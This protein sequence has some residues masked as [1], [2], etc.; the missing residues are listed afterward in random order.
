MKRIF[1]IMTAVL[2]FTV[3]LFSCGDKDNENGSESEIGVESKNDTAEDT[4]EAVETEETKKTDKKEEATVDDAESEVG[5]KADASSENAPKAT[6]NEKSDTDNKQPEENAETVFEEN[7]DTALC[8]AVWISSQASL[9]D[10]RLDPE[11]DGMMEM[12]LALFDDG[13]YI[14]AVYVDGEMLENYPQQDKYTLENG[15]LELAS[16][17]SGEING[18][19][20]DLSYSDGTNTVT[21]HCTFAA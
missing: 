1:I 6:E 4:E 7:S 2:L 8:T 9:D 14:M 18:D 20:M 3:C 10:V 17:W 5:E 19:R 11:T 15:L 13:E 12:Q 16:G 21:F